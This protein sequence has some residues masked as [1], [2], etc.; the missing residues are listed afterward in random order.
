M[1]KLRELKVLRRAIKPSERC[2]ATNAQPNP[3]DEY[4]EKP[5]YP[6]I[7]DIS[8]KARKLREA[9]SWHEEVKNLKTIEEKIIKL[10]MPRYY[11][12]KC[13]MLEGNRFPYNCIQLTQHYTRT[14]F[15]EVTDLP[16][17]YKKS[18]AT[19]DSF[20]KSV[21]DNIE[22]AIGFTTACFRQKCTDT[23]LT[24]NPV[25]MDNQLGAAIVQEINRVLLN[26]L[27]ADCSHL[28]EV[29]TDLNPRHEAFWHVGGVAPPLSLK[30]SRE[31]SAWQKEFAND[32]IDRN[33]QYLGSP[34]LA[35]RH[36][37]PLEAFVPQDSATEEVIKSVPLF[38]YDARSI[39]YSVNHRHGTTLPGFWPGS[40][41]E[42]GILSY[43]RRHHLMENNPSFG[44]VDQKEALHAQG[45]QSSFAWLLGQACYQGFSTY[46]DITYPLST[47]TI[48]TNGK[49]WSFYVYQLN[50][51]LVHS[52][53][54]YNNPRVNYCWGTDE[55]KLYEDIDKNGKCIGFNEN[56]LK[57]LIH[58]Y[59]NTPIERNINLKPYL[60]EDEQKIADIKDD[61]RRVFLERIYKH[62]MSNRP[63]HR[64]VPET[65]MW[66]KIY[67]ID[68]NTRPLEKKRR[69]FEFE[70]NPFKRR[71]DEHKSVYIPRDLR[72]LGKRSKKKWEDM[73]YP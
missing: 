69:F 70:I 14:A 55:M 25:E 58:F 56:V 20:L 68:N 32:S 60:G 49:H 22:E 9:Q 63:R 73:Y 16:E 72:P 10:N 50:T 44:S 62:M 23:G 1:L 71:L 39:G 40:P 21:K 26:T 47:Q 2:L 6:E 12:H 57:Y 29:E 3:K 43:Q 66:E 42:F 64:L 24:L 11:G 18:A 59:A 65:Y 67:K 15:E 52:N 7:L 36:K 13:V 33:V 8:Y 38:E 54:V 27:S 35:L 31:G 51:T 19:I 48:I 41:Y 37:Q 34:Y 46:N 28:L 30:K 45:I 53:F 5:N 17:T 4:T 61:K